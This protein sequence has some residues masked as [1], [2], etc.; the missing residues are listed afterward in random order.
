MSEIEK[1]PHR[2]AGFNT[3]ELAAGA[4]V[5]AV[6]LIIAFESMTYDMGSMR[7]VGPGIF[8][9][10][11]GFVL[12]GLGVAIIL[13]GRVSLAVAPSVPWRAMLSICAALGSFALLIQSF[14][15]YVAIFA[16][17]FLSGLAERKFRPVMLLC[18]WAG[19][20]VFITALVLGFRG[21]VNIDLLPGA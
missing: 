4:V 17:I 16:L 11:L 1:T 21:I 20:C 3:L 2:V 13:E 15:A 18:V 9:M 8:P 14:G 10:L 7:N 5:L 19:L 6:G 12:A